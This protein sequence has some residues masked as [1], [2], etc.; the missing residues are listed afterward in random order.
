MHMTWYTVDPPRTMIWI[1]SKLLQTSKNMDGATGLTAYFCKIGRFFG[2]TTTGH[3]FESVLSIYLS[4]R[5]S[6]S[7]E[8][9]A[10]ANGT[11]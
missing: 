10:I 3:N 8:S 5:F 9:M 11:P 2:K 1:Q 7:G 6:T 4:R